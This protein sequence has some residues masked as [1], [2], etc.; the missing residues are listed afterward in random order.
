MN[1][2]I[3]TTNNSKSG[4][5]IIEVVLV[6]AI[7]GLIFLMVFIALPALQRGQRDAQRK[8]DLTRVSVQMTHYLTSTKGAIPGSS[9]EL[10]NFVRGFLKGSS[11]TTA[12]DEYTD[13]N[14]NQYVVRYQIEPTEV[15]QIGYYPESSCDVGADEGVISSNAARDFAL[16]VKLENQAA[17]FCLD[18]KA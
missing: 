3:K 10:G 8:Q 13:P 16:T 17:P 15:G 4:F 11:N 14:G 2:Q 6:L 5:T 18:N 7:A 9:D 1:K 12:G